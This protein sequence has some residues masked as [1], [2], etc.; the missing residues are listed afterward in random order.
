MFFL[1]RYFHKLISNIIK[2]EIDSAKLKHLLQDLFLSLTK[3]K[4]KI[5]EW[6]ET[7]EIRLAN[8]LILSID[9]C[10]EFFEEYKIDRIAFFRN[11]NYCTYAKVFKSLK[12]NFNCAEEILTGLDKLD[13]DTR[14]P[15]RI[16]L[17]K[18]DINEYLQ[19][20]NVSLDF[21]LKNQWII[22]TGKNASGK[23][24]FLRAIGKILIGANQIL[25][26]NNQLSIGEALVNLNG[27]Q[28]ILNSLI[29]RKL[30]FP[31]IGLGPSRLL[32]NDDE[33]KNNPIEQE[34]LQSTLFYNTGFRFDLNT[35]ALK[36]D[37]LKKLF[38]QIDL[39]SI[40]EI[41]FDNEF[42]FK[43][44]SCNR[45]FIFHQLS[46]GNKIVFNTICEIIISLQKFEWN[47]NFQ[48]LSDFMGIVLI[49]EIEIHLHATWQKSL[50]KNLSTSFPKVQFIVTTHSPFIYNGLPNNTDSINLKLKVEG[51]E[52]TYS[53]SDDITNQHI[54]NVIEKIFDFY[55]N[56]SEF[57]SNSKTIN[58]PRLNLISQLMNINKKL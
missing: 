38:C 28:I 43:S 44:N 36:N 32:I 13:S 37:R 8:K 25:N 57:D 9:N 6:N 50:I 51:G 7:E 40:D 41:S 27:N 11:E 21:S 42:L 3:V 46:A 5:K 4:V 30:D 10:S 23:T 56:L 58:L 55:Q 53:L 34:F 16:S 2:T 47:Q 18:L 26:A 15:N 12:L 54:Y 20:E 14:L 19:I 29:S 31:I 24:S 35:I 49:D 45:D 17:L 52:F 48:N 33:E 1:N 39:P 22:I